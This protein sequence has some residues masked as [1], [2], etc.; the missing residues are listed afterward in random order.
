LLDEAEDIINAAVPRVL[1]EVEAE[2]SRGPGAF[3]RRFRRRGDR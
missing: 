1:A 3:W 2:Q